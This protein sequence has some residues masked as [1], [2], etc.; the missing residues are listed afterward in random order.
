MSTQTQQAHPDQ[1]PNNAGGFSFQVSKWHRLDRFLILGSEKGSYHVN[2]SKL[3]EDNTVGLKECLKDD[4]SR[5]IDRIA[6]IS[7]SGRAPKND[8]AIYALAI[9]ASNENPQTRRLAL[10][11]LSKVCR[12]GTHL[13]HFV[14]EMDKLRGWSRMSRSAVA[15]WYNNKTAEQVAYQAIKYQQ[16]DGWSHRDLLRLAHVKGSTAAHNAAFRWIVTKKSGEGVV[17]GLDARKVGGQLKT[18][19]FPI[20]EYPAIDRAQLPVIFQAFEKVQAAKGPEE[21]ISLIREHKLPHEAIPNQWK[22]IPA[23]WEALLEDM[24]ITAVIRNLG[25]MTA[26]GLLKPLS[27]ASNLVCDYLTND[28]ML[29]R[30]RVHPLNVLIASGT[31]GSGHGL[32]GKLSWEPVP[33][34]R[35]ALEETFYMSFKHVEPTNK[36]LYLG[37]DVS[38]SMGAKIAGTTISCME[39]SAALAMVTART[40]KQYYIAGFTTK[41]GASNWRASQMTQLDITAKS[42]LVDVM[43]VMQSVQMGGTDCALPMV[44][45]LENK[46]EVD[47][48]AVYTDS[49]TYAPNLHPHEALKN[50]RVAA[51]RDAKLIVN[52]MTSTDISIADPNDIGMLDV[53]GFDSNAPAIMADFIRS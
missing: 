5:A 33:A 28:D 2:E 42:T 6:E 24:G 30:G 9:A 50:Y 8:Q 32:L 35:D 25:K 44:H 40:E 13:F 21:V 41:T 4:A 22:D 29:R 10:N 37:L 23:V 47:A 38:A 31:Y 17:E 20:R 36:K 51:Q 45:A 1:A 11:A 52:G 49:E 12:T 43:R 46:M 18:K 53:V 48:F 14:R 26:I 16:R 34:V 7:T 27:N 19:S 39:A 3:T 15:S